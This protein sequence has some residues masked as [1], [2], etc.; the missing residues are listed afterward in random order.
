M[1]EHPD[2]TKHIFQ[3]IPEDISRIEQFRQSKKTA[4]LTVIFTDIVGYTNFTEEAGESVSTKLR[5]IHD[6]LFTSIITKDGAG[7]IVKQIGDSFLAIFAEPSTAVSRAL[8]FQKSISENKAILTHEGYTLKVRIG[9]H[10]G[11]VSLE[12]AIQPD[13]F[14]GQVNKSSRIE[15]IAQGGQILTSKEVRDN[16]IGW[17]KEKNV[18]SK[19]YGDIPLKGVKEST[20]IFEIYDL[21]NKPIG[22]PK[23]VKKK[24]LIKRSLLSSVLL[25]VLLCVF[26]IFQ[27]APKDITTDFLLVVCSN[28]ANEIYANEVKQRLSTGFDPERANNSVGVV[29]DSMRHKFIEN[30]MA[31]TS[32]EFFGTDINLVLAED[33]IATMLDSVTAMTD[34]YDIAQQI[35]AKT[36]NRYDVILIVFLC[37]EFNEDDKVIHSSVQDFFEKGS[38]ITTSVYRSINETTKNVISSIKSRRYGS[39][40]I[41]EIRKVEGNTV[42]I[43]YESEQEINQYTRLEAFQLYDWR[44]T[45]TQA[46]N[47]A[48]QKA[49]IN[50]L[51]KHQDHREYQFLDFY[52]RHLISLQA[53][54]QQKFLNST[55]TGGF[56]SHIKI[57]EVT[58]S[59]IIGNLSTDYPWVVT[60]IG[61]P[62]KIVGDW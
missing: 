12:D 56:P 45:G 8:D 37:E 14:G 1:D 42:I 29:S 53:K 50:Y 36:R 31:E 25:L 39:R 52:K 46:L 51:E 57:I 6:E 49:A 11:Q 43:R 55:G 18:G 5:H 30:T 26:W 23:S 41:G 60:R 4:V 9:I 32:T 13:I 16:A 40:N 48:D 58:D 44:K 3:L 22:P 2:V 20:A 21:S 7:E 15:S 33:N 17:L 27:M 24:R 28:Q 47:I 19:S 34:S 61:D 54:E 62:V 10:M 35:K 38:A 59:L